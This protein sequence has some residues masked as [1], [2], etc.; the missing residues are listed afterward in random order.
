MIANNVSPDVRKNR[1]FKRVLAKQGETNGAWLRRVIKEN[2]FA[3]QGLL[4][5]GGSSTPD[6]HIRVAQS[7]L[8]HDLSPSYWSHVGILKDLS[9]FYSVPLQ[10]CDE[11][12]EMP[13]RNGI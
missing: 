4:L 2:E 1:K 3:K 10:W 5:I 8:R 6:F 13:R 9:S 7:Y 11:L 12:A